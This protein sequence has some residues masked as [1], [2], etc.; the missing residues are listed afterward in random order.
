MPPIK[1]FNVHEALLCFFFLKPDLYIYICVYSIWMFFYLKCLGQVFCN[2]DPLL[3]PFQEPLGG[4]I[5]V[6]S[7]APTFREGITGK[8]LVLN[9]L[10]FW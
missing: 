2:C 4:E 8:T 1:V 7:G 9:M 5:E 10:E 6:E 3:D